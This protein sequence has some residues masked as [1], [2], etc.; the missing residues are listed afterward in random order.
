ML[1]RKLKNLIYIILFMLSSTYAN[2][3]QLVDYT[4][5]IDSNLTY[6]PSLNSNLSLIL[7]SYIDKIFFKVDLT[8]AQHQYHFESILIFVNLYS[9]KYDKNVSEKFNKFLYSS[10]RMIDNALSENIKQA[11]K[12]LNTLQF[13]YIYSQNMKNNLNNNHFLTK[14]TLN[15][16]KEEYLYLL[17]DILLPFWNTYPAWHWAKTFSNMNARLIA[18]INKEDTSLLKYHYYTAFIDEDGFSCAIASDL[19]YINNAFKNDLSLKLHT[20]KIATLK[21]IRDKCTKYIKQKSILDNNG[22]HFGIGDWSDSPSYAHAGCNKS[23]YPTNTCINKTIEP[24]ISH[25]HRLPWWIQSIRDSYNTNDS[26]Y[27]YYIKWLNHFS[28]HFNKNILIKK[29]NIFLLANY[30]N[31]ENGWYRVGYSSKHKNFGYGPSELSL[32]SGLGGYYTLAEYNKKTCNYINASNAL[33]KSEN[34][35]YKYFF[36]EKYETGYSKFLK[37]M[38]I[39]KN[40]FNYYGL[41]SMMANQMWCDNRSEYILNQE[42][43]SAK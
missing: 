5:N 30:I 2:D 8:K 7:N 42:N 9:S 13:L 43:V 32:I 40:R 34:T 14:E 11:K 41:L 19:L 22:F 1:L 10:F 3:S 31:G 29:E 24:D 39:Y 25:F 6:I 20:S 26:D 28:I 16:Y 38:D 4:Y 17:N 18:K 35:K 12:R 21:D 27:K 36:N 33:F 15:Q 23:I 37:E